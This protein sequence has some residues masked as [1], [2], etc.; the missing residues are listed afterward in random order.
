MKK[1]A[2]IKSVK[3]KGHIKVEL[4]GELGDI[5]TTVGIALYHI[6]SSLREEYQAEFRSKV[7]AALE[8]PRKKFK[9]EKINEN[10]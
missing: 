8:A 7:L 3:N 4:E 6:E 5:L 9:G 1:I 10:S 2:L